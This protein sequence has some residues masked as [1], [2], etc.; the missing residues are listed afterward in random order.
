MSLSGSHP[1]QSKSNGSSNRAV[2][3]SSS[4]YLSLALKSP[5]SAES[6]NVSNSSDPYQLTLSSSSRIYV[7][8]DMSIPLESVFTALLENVK[9]L[10]VSNG[11]REYSSQYAKNKSPHF[12]MYVAP[13]SYQHSQV[14]T[15]WPIAVVAKAKAIENFIS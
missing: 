13:S 3:S 12:P 10:H 15:F 2:R 9:M 14:V 1:F 8:T 4:P 11:S 6:S 7:Q 5:N